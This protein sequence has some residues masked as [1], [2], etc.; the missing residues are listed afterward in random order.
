SLYSLS[1]SSGHQYSSIQDCTLSKGS[2]LYPVYQGP[3]QQ[4]VDMSG[5]I[6]E[7]NAGKRIWWGCSIVTRHGGSAIGH[8]GLQRFI[9]S[10][11]GPRWGKQRVYGYRVSDGSMSHGEVSCGLFWKKCE[12]RDDAVLYNEGCIKDCLG[13]EFGRCCGEILGVH[14]RG[15]VV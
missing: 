4:S 7:S 9:R 8:H 11:R 6:R 15:V 1:I 12:I 10:L 5:K 14:S 3:G 13:N 2:F